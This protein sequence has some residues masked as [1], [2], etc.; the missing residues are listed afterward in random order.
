MRARRPVRER[1]RGIHAGGPVGDLRQRLAR[2]GALQLGH[3]R[4][5]IADVLQRMVGQC[6][7]AEG[8]LPK[9]PQVEGRHADVVY[10]RNH[11]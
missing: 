9:A 1:V 11:Q 8:E 6:A 4:L 10:Q 3:H 2:I 7:A 5:R